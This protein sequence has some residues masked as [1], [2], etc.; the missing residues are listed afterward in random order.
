MK[1]PLALEHAVAY[2]RAVLQDDGIFEVTH[3]TSPDQYR[4]EVDRLQDDRRAVFCVGAA[5]KAVT[6]LPDAVLKLRTRL[7]YPFIVFEHDLKRGWFEEILDEWL[8]E[9]LLQSSEL[10]SIEEAVRVAT[11]GDVCVITAGNDTQSDAGGARLYIGERAIE[12]AR[13]TFSSELDAEPLTEGILMCQDSALVVSAKTSDSELRRWLR[14]HSPCS[15][16]RNSMDL[17]VAT[18]V[19]NT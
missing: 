9:L 15:S 13:R 12:F 1:A 4:E 8:D 19:C 11:Q 5:A 2:M 16:E 14:T 6:G 10:E 3:A 7:A 18:A 17:Y